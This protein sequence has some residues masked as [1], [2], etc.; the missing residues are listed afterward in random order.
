MA[1]TA[2][3]AAAAT[4]ATAT[5]ATTSYAQSAGSAPA[6]PL[7]L[8]IGA[9][10]WDGGY[11]A[12]TD[13]NIAAVLV[14]GLY[15]IDGLRLSASLPWMRISSQGSVFAGVDG[16]PLVVAPARPDGKRVKEG[17]GDLTLG[18]AYLI[19]TPKAW[20]LDVDTFARVKAPTASSSSGLSTGEA[21]YA[22]GVEVTKPMGRFAPFVSVR[23]RVF[24]NPA[25][26]QLND[27][28]GTSVGA[29]YVFPNR[30][31]VVA[32]YD[33]AASASRF[34]DDSHEIS[35]S[36]SAPVA[37]SPL[38]LTG[39]ASAGLSSGAADVSGGLSVS[40]KL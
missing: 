16:T 4:L 14:T 22:F 23:Y 1:R 10:D 20:G 3:L 8:G 30:V 21:D 18:A 37:R 29:S 28:F 11:G 38:R 33:Y 19:A 9:T 26:T 17:L 6:G 5:M 34:L 2:I 35:A 36:V 7:T 32:S 13:T 27:G 40:L 24:G 25:W 12:R 15:K 31:A 39:F